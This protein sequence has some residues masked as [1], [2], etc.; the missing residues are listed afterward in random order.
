MQPPGLDMCQ[1]IMFSLRLLL[2]LLLFSSSA[3]AAADLEIKT[4]KGLPGKEFNLEFVFMNHGPDTANNVGCNVYFYAT[5]RLILSQ[6]FKLSSLASGTSRREQLKMEFPNEP[7]TTV[8]VEVFDSDQPDVQPSTNFMQ[9]NIKP[10]DLRQADLQIVKVESADLKEKGKNILLVKLRNNGPS[11]I[12]PSEL[13][14]SL[15]VFGQPLAQLNKRIERMEAGTEVE[16]RVQIPT[17]PVIPATNGSIILR[18]TGTDVEESE[19]RNNVYKFD[20]PLA[21]R[22]PDLQPLKAAIDKQGVLTFSVGNKGNARA[23]DSVTALY[24]NGALVERY[25]TPDMAPRGLQQYR[26]NAKKLTSEDKVVVIVDFNAEVQESS[27]ENN[28]TP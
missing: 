22:M 18:W 13:N 26:Y 17:A 16:T 7:I 1:T 19:A 5:E 14:V 20:V 23:E 9:M 25:N 8:K 3:F 21:L 15:E 28:R 27:E 4:L 11:K 2:L 10:P 24:I 6:A 12:G